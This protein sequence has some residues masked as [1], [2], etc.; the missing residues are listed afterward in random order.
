[1]SIDKPKKQ[2][3]FL[4]VLIFYKNYCSEDEPDAAFALEATL[5]F[6]R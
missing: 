6:E 3:E 1:M 4:K 5:F 2:K